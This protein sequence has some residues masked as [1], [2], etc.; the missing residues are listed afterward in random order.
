MRRL[1]RAM[2]DDLFDAAVATYGDPET[3][4]DGAVVLRRFASA[5]EL[6]LIECVH[7][8]TA[9]APFRNM[10]TPGGFR[11]SV[12]MSNCGQVGWVT[13]RTGYRY[14]PLDPL[15]GRPW[16]SMPE[17]VRAVAIRAAGAAGFAAFEPDACLINRYEPGTR[18][19]VHQDR[20]ERNLS[21]P[22]VSISLGL[23]ATF[24]FGG[25][26]RR[27]RPRRLRLASTDVVVWGGRARLAFH[28]VAP[29]D[30]GVHPATG[31]CRLNLTVR[32][33]L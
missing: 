16:P 13:D 2:V 5:E 3:L 28:G 9:A 19:S 27:E 8:V 15:T 24:L 7:Y 25:A 6:A 1:P 18:L 12:A 17:P 23:P 33:A 32:A 4:T 10:I 21:A 26:E 22:V 14:D 29:L 20:N 30:E 31:R 11:M